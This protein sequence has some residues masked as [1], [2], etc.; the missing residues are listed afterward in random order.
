MKRLAVHVSVPIEV[1]DDHDEN[2]T[3]DEAQRLVESVTKSLYAMA[4]LRRP[5]VLAGGTA[6]IGPRGGRSA[7]RCDAEGAP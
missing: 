7:P 2:L 1:A 4:A 3:L 5:T 6:R